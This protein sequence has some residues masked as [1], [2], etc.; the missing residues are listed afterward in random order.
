MN[1]RPIHA[2]AFLWGL[3]EATF[4][5]IV[6]DVLL[7][8]L[9]LRDYRSAALACLWALA[10]ALLGGFILWLAARQGWTPFLPAGFDRIPGISPAMIAES[11]AALESQGWI[12]LGQGVLSGRPYKLYAYHAGQLGAHPLGFL[13]ASAVARLARFLATTTLAWGIGRALGS[14]SM[15]FRLGLHLAAWL[16]FYAMYFAA[17]A[18]P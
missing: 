16:L 13:A 6:P 12:A 9:A 1:S 5:F 3:A 10:G 15:R 2:S 14:R 11:A 4:F 18:A 7:T 8:R 17:M